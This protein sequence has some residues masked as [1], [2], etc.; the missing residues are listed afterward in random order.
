MCG[1]IACVASNGTK[2]VGEATLR[3]LNDLMRHRGPDDAGFIVEDTASM[4]MRRLSIVDIAGGHQPM[5]TPDGRYTLIFNGE[6]YNH[7][8]LRASLA[9]QGHRLRTH[10]DTEVLLYHLI[11]HG[12]EGLKELNGMF[13]FCLW[14]SQKKTLFVGRDRLGIKPL[15][16]AATTAGYIFAS[17]LTPILKSGF[18]KPKISLKAVSDYLAY[19]YVA[20]PRTMIEGVY[21]LP[22]GHW[23]IVEEGRMRMNRWWSIPTQEDKNISYGQ[24]VSQVRE[25]LEDAVKIRLDVDVPLGTFL[26]GGIDSGLVTSFASVHVPQRLTAYG[27]GFPQKS[28]DE[29]PQAR[30]T[31][32][33][34][35]VHL[36][37]TM[38][39]SV[40][41]ALIE[42]I[43]TSFDEPLGN[44]SFVPTYIL[45]QGAREQLKVV[46]TGDG[47]DELFGGYPTYQAPLYQAVWG[48]TPL[49]FKNLFRWATEH[50]PV[51]H[52]RISLDY[53]LKQLLKG[54]EEDYR[55][56]H[57]TWRLVAG[58]KEQHNLWQLPLLNR[59]DHYDPF[60]LIDKYFNQAQGLSTTNQLMY[61]DLNTFL[62]DDHLRKVDRM[63]MAH[64]LEARLPFLDYR[65]VELAMRLPS[66]YKVTAL[67][68]KRL[69][70]DAAKGVL[71]SGVIHGKKKGLT[72]PIAGWL[73]GPLKEYAEQTLKGGLVAQLFQEQEVKRLW[74]Q[75][76]N[77]Q[78]DN[79]RLLWALLTLQIWAKNQK[80]IEV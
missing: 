73:T 60:E 18:V 5:A 36:Q 47:G 7:K 79:S 4:A 25:L 19:W 68:T 30:Q 75:H 24:A 71:P 57:Y 8:D 72:A 61:A 59:L 56:A 58:M 64:G 21:Q 74:D 50:L 67:Q 69:L 23:A 31:A 12:P 46:L 42:K 27:I 2:P 15:Y 22:A 65:L 54:V 1:I 20:Q 39:P 37:E 77:R 17:E 33:L 32:R 10:S 43:I 9:A 16:Y 26:S 41:A 55:R 80:G 14:D 28:Y 66:G 76:Q 44:A 34:H 45:A 48:K 63:T 78:Y 38:M 40:N 11:E 13:A 52:N 62:L 53:R 49:V 6:I 70:K 29:M 51:S 35:G 3:Q